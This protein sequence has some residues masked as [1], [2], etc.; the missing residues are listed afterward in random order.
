MVAN[1]FF[2][3][4]FMNGVGIRAIS[5]HPGVVLIVMAAIIAAVFIA[6]CIPLRR[7]Q[8]KKPMDIFKAV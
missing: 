4:R 7:L 1:N 5:T 8:R 3:D 2:V 6:V